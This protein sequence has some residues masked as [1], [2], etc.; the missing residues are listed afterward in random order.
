MLR[1]GPE[2]KERKDRGYQGYTYLT[3]CCGVLLC[4]AVIVLTM[5][6]RVRITALSAE[7]AALETH[8]QALRLAYDRALV[9]REGDRSLDRIAAA[10]AALGMQPPGRGGKAFLRAPDTDLV[11]T[12]GM[13][14]DGI[15]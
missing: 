12:Y 9:D 5:A 10:A 11:I 8:I 13:P 7:T 3:L 14:A 15:S 1:R 4:A 2:K 6:A